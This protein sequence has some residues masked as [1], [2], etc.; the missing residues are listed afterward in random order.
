V[1]LDY[2]K[3]KENIMINPKTNQPFTNAEKARGTFSVIC[4][5]LIALMLFWPDSAEKKAIK[6]EQARIAK[7]ES[8]NMT[9]LQTMILASAKD[10]KSIEW[11]QMQFS[12]KRENTCVKYSGTNSFG[13]RVTETKCLSN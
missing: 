7:I 8:H 5:I 3:L 11:I 9:I 4:L 12:T 6:A 13:G 1:V 2:I 10:A